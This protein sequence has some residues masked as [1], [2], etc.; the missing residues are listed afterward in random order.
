MQQNKA[1]CKVPRLGWGNPKHRYRLVGEWMESSMVKN[2]EILQAVSRNMYFATEEQLES[3]RI[4]NAYVMCEHSF[5]VFV[6]K[7][8]EM[9]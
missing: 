9:M 1:K 6:L 2:L 4:N 3:W 7:K 8:L 5:C